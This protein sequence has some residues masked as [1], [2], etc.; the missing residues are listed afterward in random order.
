VLEALAVK[1]QGYCLLTL[2]RPS[3]VDSEDTLRLLLGAVA[4]I[5]EECPVVFPVHPRTR[6]HLERL[7][8]HLPTMANPRLVDPLPY[9]KFV[10]PMSNASCVLTDSGGIQQN[11]TELAIN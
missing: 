3:N 4:R 6:Q 7:N 10:H 1:P 11:T 9:L 2:H 8:G 5:Q